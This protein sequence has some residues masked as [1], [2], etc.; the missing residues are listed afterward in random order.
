[1]IFTIIALIL[2][3]II[4]VEVERRFKLSDT[5]M[6]RQILIKFG[7]NLQTVGRELQTSNIE[8][9]NSKENQTPNKTKV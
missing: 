4:G 8:K 6:Y 9:Q 7:Q 1:M 2:G 3:I 5:P